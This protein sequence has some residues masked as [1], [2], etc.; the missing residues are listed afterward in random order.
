MASFVALKVKEIIRETSKAVSLVFAIT[1]ELKDT[2]QFV[3]GQF[4]TLRATINNQ[5][6][7]RAYSISSSPHESHLQV[8]IKEIEGGIFSTYA[9]RVLKIGDT[10]E[11]GIPEGKFLLSNITDEPKSYLAFVSGS[12]ITPVLSMIKTVLTQSAESRFVLVFGN[13]TEEDTMFLQVLRRLQSS[14]NSRLFIEW[15]Y[16]RQISEGNHIGRINTDL[17]TT[18]LD[19]KYKDFN[20]DSVYLCGPEEMIYTLRNKSLPK[21]FKQDQIYFELFTTTKQDEQLPLIT[22]Q[23]KSSVEVT[24]LVDDEEE[25]IEV[26]T[27][28]T[29]LDAAIE[30][31]IDA[32]YSCKGGVCCSCICRVVEGEVNMKDNEMLTEDEKEEGLILSCISYAKTGQVIKLDFDD[33]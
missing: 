32:P 31:D 26:S 28:K 2:F 19:Q 7:R 29:L 22:E 17:V 6:V 27:E 13:R 20:F 11:V 14:Y 18:I 10:L 23:E 30:A 4:V 12:G 33:A 15:V 8:S 25:T 21:Y 5:E 16:S 24:Y 1:D 9:N 3:A